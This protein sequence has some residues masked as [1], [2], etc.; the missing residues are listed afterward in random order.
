M[1]LLCRPCG[2][3]YSAQA[4]FIGGDDEASERRGDGCD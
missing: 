2:W 1:R 3:L 4:V